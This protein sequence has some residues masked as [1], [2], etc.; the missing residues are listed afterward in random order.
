VVAEIAE[1]L[2][3]PKADEYLAAKIESDRVEQECGF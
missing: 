3:A 2:I 1:R